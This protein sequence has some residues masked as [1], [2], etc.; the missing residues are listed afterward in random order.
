MILAFIDLDLRRLPNVLV[1]LLAVIGL[2]GLLVAQL[3]LV[4]RAPDGWLSVPLVAGLAG[5]ALGAG[6]SLA[7]AL[8]YGLVRGKQ[9]MGM[10][11]VKLLGAIG[12]FLGPYVVR[13]FFVGTVLGVVPALLTSRRA[14]GGVETRAGEANAEAGRPD[15]AAAP[16]KP[17]PT[18]AIPFGPFLAA[19]AVLTAVWGPTLWLWYASM[20]GL[21]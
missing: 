5:A 13:A 18:G 1:A 17:G 6:L 11:D 10:G 16:E 21:R 12:L 2:L 9:G 3:P 7:L 20:V 14:A 15:A 4:G 8:V 19:G